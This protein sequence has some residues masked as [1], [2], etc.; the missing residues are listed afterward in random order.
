MHKA[1]GAEGRRLRSAGSSRPALASA[2]APGAAGPGAGA[3]V[4]ATVPQRGG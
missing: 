4:P 3:G 1:T 2:G